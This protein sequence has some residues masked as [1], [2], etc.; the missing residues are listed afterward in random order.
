M[1]SWS[2][3][4]GP[5]A[6]C[7]EPQGLEHAG[8]QGLG[9]V[10]TGD[11][12]DELRQH[13]VGRGRVVLVPRPDVPVQAPFGERL[14]G[15]PRE[16]PSAGGAE[17]RMGEPR[18]VLEDVVEGDGLLAVGP[19]L[20]DELADRHLGHQ[21]A[22]GHELPHQRCDERLGRRED[23]EAGVDV[24]V[25]ERLVDQHLAVEGERQL[26]PREQTVVDLATGP[27]EE[28][29]TALRSR[30]VMAGTLVGECQALPAACH[31]LYAHGRDGAGARAPAAPR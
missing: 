27:R 18:R 21:G 3:S 16:C 2:S 6:S 4:A 12:V 11:R 28:A 10:L 30:V 1:R 23:R 29:S 5:R 8:A 13:P 9:V 19:E 14:R 20:R 7:D 26:A 22:F 25:A 15:G 31:R 24:G 17:R